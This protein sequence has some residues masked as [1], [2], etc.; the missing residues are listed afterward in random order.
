MF[1]LRSKVL[2]FLDLENLSLLYNQ[3]KMDCYSSS[4][5]SPPPLHQN[6]ALSSYVLCR[7]HQCIQNF[8]ISFECLFLYFSFLFSGFTENYPLF[9]FI[10]SSLPLQK[11]IL[12]SALFS[13]L[14]HSGLNH[15][16]TSF[17][18][19]LPPSPPSPPQKVYIM[20]PRYK[21]KDSIC[22]PALPYIKSI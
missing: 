13:P 22:S 17:P 20:P 19:Q 4:V 8:R 16:W 7:T 6:K 11:I 9:S 15:I 5:T 10:Q 12:Y 3:Q 2:K 1:H 18:G 21:G 14:T